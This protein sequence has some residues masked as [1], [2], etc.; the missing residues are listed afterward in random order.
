LCRR[1]LPSGSSR[2]KKKWLR[3]EEISAEAGTEHLKAGIKPETELWKLCLILAA[4]L[5]VVESLLLRKMRG[6]KT[7]AI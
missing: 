4:V 2:A 7:S 3:L 5:L 6:A 1:G